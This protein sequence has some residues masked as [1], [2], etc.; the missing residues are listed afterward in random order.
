MRSC[1]FDFEEGANSQSRGRLMRLKRRSSARRRPPRRGLVLRTFYAN[2]FQSI[3]SFYAAQSYLDV[4]MI[5][6]PMIADQRSGRG[7]LQV[8]VARQRPS[9]ILDLASV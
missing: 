4:R 6:Q 5:V 2:S 7:A 8:R 9:A 1:A 3:S